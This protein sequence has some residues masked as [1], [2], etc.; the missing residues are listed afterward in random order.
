[1]I[2]RP[3]RSTLFP[4]TTL[5]R[6][7]RGR[8]R[9][10]TATGRPGPAGSAGS[11]EPPGLQPPEQPREGHQHA[12][13]PDRRQR[14]PPVPAEP[15]EPGDD[16]VGDDDQQPDPDRRDD[17]GRHDRPGPAQRRTRLARHRDPSSREGRQLT[18]NAVYIPFW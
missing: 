2:R 4:Y 12:E 10:P 8:A 15:D 18:V 1:M 11:Y 14:H 16:Q 3:P 5:F 13:E 7:R 6:S 17:G 9:S